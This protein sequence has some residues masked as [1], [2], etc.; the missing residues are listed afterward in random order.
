MKK[1]LLSLILATITACTA[2]T[3]S[4]VSA[5]GWDN[6]GRRWEC[7]WGTAAYMNPS[8]YEFALWTV[9]GPEKNIWVNGSIYGRIIPQFNRDV[10][11]W[12]S[13]SRT[14]IQNGGHGT[15]CDGITSCRYATSYSGVANGSNTQTNWITS[16]SSQVSHQ[17]YV[18]KN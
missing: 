1:K 5:A 17:G 12:N 11:I 16:G 9:D 15:S 14:F 3:L 10:E 6:N 13:R 7:M 4:Y 8:D 2:F 18:Y